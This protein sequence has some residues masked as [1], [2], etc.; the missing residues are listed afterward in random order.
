MISYNNHSD[1]KQ[2]SYNNYDIKKV[3]GCG[4]NLVWEKEPQPFDGK[5]LATYSDSHTAS[6][7]CG[8]S[9]AIRKNE[10]TNTNFVSLEIGHCVTNID[11]YAFNNCT[12]LT[13]VTIPNSVT[14]I[15]NQ[16]FRSC[17]GLTSIDI[18]DS[19]TSINNYVFVEC[20]S[21]TSVTIGNSVAY[22]GYNAFN[23]CTSLT[24][25]TINATTPPTLGNDAISGTNN[26]P[27][28]VPAESVDAYK[29][30][31]GWGIYASRIQAIP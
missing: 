2:I 10:I 1:I 18:P 24:S 9:S 26:C 22:I 15:G 27:I 12:K 13:C 29:S 5:W 16:A 3:Y 14:T 17:S 4:G 7:E 11:D 6:A 30:A 19:V 21:L 23:W 8:A 20:Y 31:S 28:Y 25:I